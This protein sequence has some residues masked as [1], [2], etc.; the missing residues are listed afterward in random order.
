MAACSLTACSGPAV[1]TTLP[2]A[3]DEPVVLTHCGPSRVAAIGQ[4]KQA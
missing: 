3:T 1:E 2:A 4:R